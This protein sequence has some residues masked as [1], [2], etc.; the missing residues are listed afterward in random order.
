[1]SGKRAPVNAGTK[2]HGNATLEEFA[3][4]KIVKGLIVLSVTV[5][6]TIFIDKDSLPD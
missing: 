6:I 3:V 5:L 4:S 1:V 2:I